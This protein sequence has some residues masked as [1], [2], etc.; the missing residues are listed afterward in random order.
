M[1]LNSA[2]IPAVNRVFDNLASAPITGHNRNFSKRLDQS[3][4][5]FSSQFIT[6]SKRRKSSL[7]KSTQS[8]RPQM[9]LRRESDLR[10]HA[11][12]TSEISISMK[13]SVINRYKSWI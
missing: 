10:V 1:V 12:S 3:K 9:H 8:A 7:V 2:R 5:S 6:E 11:K 13:R 4:T